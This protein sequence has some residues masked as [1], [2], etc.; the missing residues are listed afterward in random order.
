MASPK[1]PSVVPFV[2]HWRIA[3]MEQWDREYIDPV[4]P[5]YI[6]IA[7]GS[8]GEFHFGTLQGDIDYRVEI[9]VAG[10]R[11]EFSWSGDNEAESASG[12]GWASVVDDE[13]RGRL[14]I[15]MGD[16]SWFIAKRGKRA[17]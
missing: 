5:G 1:K 2:G 10:P 8:L 15:H 9:S 13:L 17:I 4:V 11:L 6:R 7:K 3:E 14:F 16:D 12:R